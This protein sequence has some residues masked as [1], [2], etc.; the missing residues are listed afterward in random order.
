METSTSVHVLIHGCILRKEQKEIRLKQR[1]RED[2][3]ITRD[4]VAL[5]A[6]IT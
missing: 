6:E 3:V 5:D 4:I 1:Q 2:S